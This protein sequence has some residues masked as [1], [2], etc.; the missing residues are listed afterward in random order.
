[1]GGAR[2][3]EAGLQNGAP[4]NTGSRERDLEEKWIKEQ[5]TRIAAEQKVKEVTAEIEE[6]SATLFEEANK[7]V[8][9][10]RKEKATLAEKLQALEHQQQDQQQK[11]E[12]QN[13]Q[14]NEVA[15]GPRNSEKLEK[16]NARLKDRIRT[17]EKRDADRRKRLDRLE[18]AT[19]RIERVKAMLQPP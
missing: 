9:I 19:K 11:H 1:M 2:K 8:A 4:Q 13:Q 3:S 14:L 16:D 12:H 18:A 7:M 10:E 5:A 15:D 6:L 17:L